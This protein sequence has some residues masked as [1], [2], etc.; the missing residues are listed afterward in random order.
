MAVGEGEALTARGLSFVIPAWNE[1]AGIER[2]VVA[3]REA[4]E[5][6]IADGEIAAFEIVVVDD[7]ST[8][9]TG[10]L[11]DRL[12]PDEPQ[13]RVVHHDRNRGL[14]GAIRTGFSAAAGAH[15]LYT[16]ADLPFDLAEVG[17]AFRLLRQHDADIVAM[18]RR[19]RHGEGPRRVVYS[20][21][22]NLLVRVALGLRLRD[23]NFAGKLMRRE[24]VDAVELRSD[25]SFIDVELLARATAKGFRVVQFGVDYLPRTRGVSTLSSLPVIVDIVREMWSMLPEL[26]S[27]GP[28][29]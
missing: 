16:D 4:G 3:A 2:T 12:T 28:L 10:D 5:T 25:G 20:Y 8:D 26:R 1:R 14:G 18:Y 27:S 29:P 7:A 21:G 15:V 11:L 17:R 23:V 9:G 6:L 19:D 13:L 22:Y 24:V